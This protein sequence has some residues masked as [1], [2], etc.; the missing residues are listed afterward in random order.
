[1]PDRF[2]GDHAH[3]VEN[4]IRCVKMDP[5]T[6]LTVMGMATEKLGLG[7]TYSTTYYEPYHVARVVRDAGSDERWA[8]GMECRDVDE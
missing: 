3:A 4:G 5:V 6:I 8:R 2:G 1:M 7:A